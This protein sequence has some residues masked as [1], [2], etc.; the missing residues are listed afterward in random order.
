MRPARRW[1]AALALFTVALFAGCNR[2]PT[3]QM[4][5]GVVV[6]VQVASFSQ[7]GSFDLRT[8]EGEVLTFA[9]EGNPGITPGHL[10]EHMI[11]AQPVIVTYHRLDGDLIATL[12]DDA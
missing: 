3:V 1:L 5:R 8:D 12:I 4:A 7:I 6:N 11:L 2:E 10:R 9:V